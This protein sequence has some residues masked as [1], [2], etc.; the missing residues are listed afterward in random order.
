MARTVGS[1]AKEITI[2]RW[3][4]VGYKFNNKTYMFCKPQDKYTFL[5]LEDVAAH[6]IEWMNIKKF[7]TRFE[8]KETIQKIPE[9]EINGSLV[10]LE[11]IKNSY[12]MDLL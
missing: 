2:E 4:G 3:Y 10:V 5:P 8:A 12:I 9:F 1:K 11:P 7:E 6:D